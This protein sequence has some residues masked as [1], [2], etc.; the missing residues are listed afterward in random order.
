MVRLFYYYDFL[1]SLNGSSLTSLYVIS[2][3][4]IVKNEANEIIKTLDF[5]ELI[6]DH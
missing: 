4:E 2:G 5:D 1:T 6:L 3:K